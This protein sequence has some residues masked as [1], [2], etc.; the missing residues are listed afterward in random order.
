MG[1]DGGYV[2]SCEQRSRQEGWFE[3]I[4]A[5]IDVLKLLVE[6]ETMSPARK[7]LLK[8]LEDFGGYIAANRDFSLLQ[9]AQVMTFYA[10]TPG[11]NAGCAR[12]VR[13]LWGG[14]SRPCHS[15]R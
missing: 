15:G 11:F 6:A 13:F 4:V 12:M 8:A 7:K 3:V 1:L 9:T 10:V 5:V 14:R 2:H